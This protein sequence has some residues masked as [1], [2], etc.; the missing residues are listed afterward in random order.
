MRTN[1]NPE[2]VI[3]FARAAGCLIV[4]LLTA[5]DNVSW[6]GV[7]VTVVPPPPRPSG[8]PAPGVEPGA[9]RLPQGPVLFH[10][11]ASGS[12]GSMVPVGEIDGDSLLPLRALS[13][14]WAYGEN[15]IAEHMRQGREFVLFREGIRAGTFLV[16]AAALDST[17][18]G[19]VPEATGALELGEAGA[20]VEEFLALERVQAPQIPRRA[21][22]PL[23]ATRAMRVIA[24]IDADQLL[25]RRRAQLP[26]N[27]ARAMAQLMVIGLSD[28]RNPGFTA[29]FLVGD[30]LGP[31]LDDNGHSL[32]FVAMPSQLGY[33]TVYVSFNSYASTGKA[34]PEVIDFLDWDR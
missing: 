7:D 2:A 27:W 6:G 5:C 19:P 16:S 20:G 17:A 32:F 28:T 9:E 33:D 31:G 21:A 4:I 10:V 25:R 29:T 15:F 34:A 22:Q 12:V 8:Q 14:P 24:P 13:D 11:T 3:A 30:T 1:P 26:G 18:C 23:E